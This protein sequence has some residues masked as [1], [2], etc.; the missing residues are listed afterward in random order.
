MLKC[1]GVRLSPEVTGQSK[2]Q[3]RETTGK[4]TAFAQSSVAWI[5]HLNYVLPGRVKWRRNPEKLKREG[6]NPNPV[7]IPPYNHLLFFS[8]ILTQTKPCL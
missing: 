2:K 8:R 6:G 7:K 1:K 5:D 4:L 3:S